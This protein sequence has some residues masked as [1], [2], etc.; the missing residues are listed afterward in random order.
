MHMLFA[1]FF[2]HLILDDVHFSKSVDVDPPFKEQLHCFLLSI[3]SVV[4]GAPSALLLNVWVAYSFALLET[5]Q[6]CTGLDIHFCP[7]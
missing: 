5:L 2:P 3:P 4:Q 7:V 1:T 6:H